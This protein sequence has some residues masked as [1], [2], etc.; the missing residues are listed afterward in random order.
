MLIETLGVI[1]AVSAA[2]GPTALAARAVHDV[3]DAHASK[4]D[5]SLHNQKVHSR[6]LK[7]ALDAASERE[8][9]L[10]SDLEETQSQLDN[11]LNLLLK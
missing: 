1:A 3:V 10:T 2:V 4:L 5:V 7:A 6:K 9:K 8:N 11:V